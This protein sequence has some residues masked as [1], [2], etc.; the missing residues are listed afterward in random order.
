M[1]EE[2]EI[3]IKNLK[4]VRLSKE[5]IDNSVKRMYM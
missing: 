3:K 5:E 4:K 2:K 1:I